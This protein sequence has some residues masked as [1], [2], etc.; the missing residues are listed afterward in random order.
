MR[1]KQQLKISQLKKISGPSG[2]IEEFYQSFKEELTPIL[3]KLLHK[4]EGGGNYPNHFYKARI[5]LIPKLGKEL[6]KQN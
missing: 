6:N 1:Q 5:T 2:F 4:I 3:L